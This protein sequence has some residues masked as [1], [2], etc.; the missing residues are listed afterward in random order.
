MNI[1]KEWTEYE[2][3]ETW[4][5]IFELEVKKEADIE[6]E[7]YSEITGKEAEMISFDGDEPPEYI[8]E[9]ACEEALQT[10][11]EYY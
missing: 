9:Q 5:S 1:S 6:I 10:E 7:I 4:S 11:N 2:S 8:I 3:V